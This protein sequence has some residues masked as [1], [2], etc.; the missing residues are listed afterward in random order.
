MIESGKGREARLLMSLLRLLGLRRGWNSEHQF[1]GNLNRTR[2]T[3]L[4][5]L[6]QA[7]VAAEVVAQ[8]TPSLPKQAVPYGVVYPT[9][10]RMVE[11]V[12]EFA[13][14]L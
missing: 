11:N 12:K 9:K 6:I 5:E 8:C 10:I 1:E 13:T 3:D 4:V 7:T 2:T 14:E